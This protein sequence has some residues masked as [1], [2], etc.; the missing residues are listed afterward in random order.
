MGGIFRQH[1]VRRRKL[2]ASCRAMRHEKL[3]QFKKEGE[4]AASLV[5]DYCI[6]AVS[7]PTM[8]Y[9]PTKVSPY[10]FSCS[11]NCILANIYLD[12]ISLV[13]N[14]QASLFLYKSRPSDLC[15]QALI[16]VLN[17]SFQ[18]SPNHSPLPLHLTHTHPKAS[19]R[20]VPSP[21]AVSASRHPTTKPRSLPPPPPHS[22][23]SRKMY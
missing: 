23:Y 9:S 19:H 16:R 11:P 5:S 3:G 12:A 15:I 4:N 8:K 7:F 1:I 13:I 6:T 2:G 21:S 20:L 22:L 18:P 10:P 17:L 14:N